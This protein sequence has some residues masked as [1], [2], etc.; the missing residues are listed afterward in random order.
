VRR[1][2]PA[3]ELAAIV[4]KPVSQ[5]SSCA[6]AADGTLFITSARAGLPEQ[7]LAG[8]PHAGSVF[9]LA[10]TTAGVPVAPFAG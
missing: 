10:T 3:G 7:E 5:P 4:P 8:Q 2:S 9:A 1:Y 6:F